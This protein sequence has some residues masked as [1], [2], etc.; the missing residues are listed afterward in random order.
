MASQTVNAALQADGIEVRGE[1]TAGSAEILTP[2][3][4]R[5]VAE[6]ARRF[7]DVLGRVN[8]TFAESAQQA[9]LMVAGRALD[10]T[11]VEMVLRR[12]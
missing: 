5:F 7:E 4:M 8:A 1:P 11:S 9:V 6:L 10:L 3:A 12:S 2:D